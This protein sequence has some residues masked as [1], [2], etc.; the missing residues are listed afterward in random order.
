MLGPYSC[1]LTKMAPLSSPLVLQ[2]QQCPVRREGYKM[3]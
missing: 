3:G 1:E 2:L